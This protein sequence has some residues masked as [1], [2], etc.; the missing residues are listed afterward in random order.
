[1]DPLNVHRVHWRHSL[2]HS[3]GVFAARFCDRC[4]VVRSP[5]SDKMMLHRVPVHLQLLSRCLAW[6]FA[7]CWWNQYQNHLLVHKLRWVWKI[8]WE[9]VAMCVTHMKSLEN[10][11]WNKNRSHYRNEPFIWISMNPGTM[12][13]PWQSIWRWAEIFRSKNT[14]SGLMILPFCIQKSS[15]ITWWLRTSRQLRKCRI[16]SI[17][18]D[19]SS[20]VHRD[21]RLQSSTNKKK[22]RHQQLKYK[23]PNTLLI[24]F[25][26]RL[27][28][29]IVVIATY[30]FVNAC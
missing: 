29:D 6:Y 14:G 17:I 4:V 26:N 20:A 19:S 2:S 10:Y 30:N 7:Y 15:S 25:M 18:Q 21:L 16:S 11:N 13:A 27:E 9:N 24:Q 12:I 5:A 1:M 23:T 3:F 28:V 8:K 22:P